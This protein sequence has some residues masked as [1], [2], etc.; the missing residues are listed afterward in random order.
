MN[1]TLVSWNSPH[2]MSILSDVVIF[3]SSIVVLAPN[4]RFLDCATSAFSERHVAVFRTA[5]FDTAFILKIEFLEVW[6]TS[7]DKESALSQ[8]PSHI[9]KSN[10]EKYGYMIEHRGEFDRTIIGSKTVGAFGL[11]S[12]ASELL[13]TA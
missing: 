6:L 1:G 11:M 9:A 3:W 12:T 8:S 5:C 13:F 4:G 2:Q 7:C 10:K